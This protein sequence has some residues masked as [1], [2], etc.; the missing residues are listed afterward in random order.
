MQPPF[1]IRRRRAA[2]A[3]C[4]AKAPI[5]APQGG[6][7][8]NDLLLTAHDAGQEQGVVLRR[9]AKCLLNDLAIA[10]IDQLGTFFQHVGEHQNDHAQIVLLH[11]LLH[12]PQELALAL[13]HLGA[14][15]AG[16]LRHGEGKFVADPAT[17]AEIEKRNLVA[18][19]Y[20]NADGS[21][22]TE[23][24]L[25]LALEDYCY[26]LASSRETRRRTN[27][28]IASFEPIGK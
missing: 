23:L 2:F 5:L 24:D 27:V 25:G 13:Q 11:L 22:A 18:V 9:H 12:Q 1:E 16:D 21:N 4:R 6:Q 3:G 17:L 15:H 19:R 7:H 28:T 20:A 8:G 14:V 26:L 10:Q